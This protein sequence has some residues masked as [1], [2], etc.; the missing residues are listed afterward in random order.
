MATED[1]SVDGDREAAVLL[2]AQAVVGK[3]LDKSPVV[4]FATRGSQI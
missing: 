3:T 1:L 4:T 2:V